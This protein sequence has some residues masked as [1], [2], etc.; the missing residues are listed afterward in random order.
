M[1][2]FLNFVLKH[3]ILEDKSKLPRFL[4]YQC[5]HKTK[6]QK[7]SI[8][9]QIENFLHFSFKESASYYVATTRFTSTYIERRASYAVKRVLPTLKDCLHKGWY[10]I[11]KATQDVWKND[12]LSWKLYSHSTCF[13]DQSRKP[14]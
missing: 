4:L 11:S 10:R 1:L 3:W 7:I 12:V 5:L 8:Q 13:R 14:R 9:H 6:A 2:Q